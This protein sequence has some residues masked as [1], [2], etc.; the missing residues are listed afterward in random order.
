MENT[1]ACGFAEMAKVAPIFAEMAAIAGL[2]PK[3][4]YQL[5]EIEQASGIAYTT[6]SEDAAAGKIKTFLPPG[7]KRGRMIKPEWFDEWFGR[8]INA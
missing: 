3:G 1:Y 8:G 2:K 6:I 5:R 7:R 4:A